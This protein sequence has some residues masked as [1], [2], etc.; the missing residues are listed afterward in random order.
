MKRSFEC[1]I[2]FL[3]H[4]RFMN[5]V[6]SIGHG[7]LFSKNEKPVPGNQRKVMGE[8]GGAPPG[9]CHGS[10]YM[11]WTDEGPPPAFAA[12]FCVVLPWSPSFLKNRDPHDQCNHQA[13]SKS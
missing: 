6:T 1:H 9:N 5:K 11:E 10:P 8:A 12:P 7:D 4:F 2:A 3:D 13:I